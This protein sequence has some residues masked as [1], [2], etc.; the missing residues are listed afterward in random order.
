MP[1]PRH[2][3]Q[4]LQAG[5]AGFSDG[6]V[7]EA[8]PEPAPHLAEP[9]QQGHAHQRRNIAEK[10]VRASGGGGG[11]DDPGPSAESSVSAAAKKKPS[12]ATVWQHPVGSSSSARGT[13]KRPS[14]ASDLRA[15][16]V[17]RRQS[18]FQP[19]VTILGQ[20]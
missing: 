7:V 14:T 3:I 20:I 8:M 15:A 19:P 18:V 13:K 2:I 11:G 9:L 12:A 1:P 10:L 17:S 6:A 5:S 4:S 16:A